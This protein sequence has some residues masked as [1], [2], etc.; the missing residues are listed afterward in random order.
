[1]D[2]IFPDNDESIWEETSTVVE[3][4]FLDES[5]SIFEDELTTDVV[6]IFESNS[7]TNSVTNSTDNSIEALFKTLTQ[8]LENENQE[9][10]AKAVNSLSLIYSQGI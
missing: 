8:Q 9:N 7:V 2:S 3:S 10:L 4:I 5:E 1:M 6:N